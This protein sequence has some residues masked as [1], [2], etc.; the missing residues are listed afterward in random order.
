MSQ[1]I[2]RLNTPQR[3]FSGASQRFSRAAS[4]ISPIHCAATVPEGFQRRKRAVFEVQFWRYRTGLP[5]AYPEV[6][7]GEFRGCRGRAHALLRGVSPPFARD[8]ARARSRAAPEPEGGAGTLT[9]ATVSRV[10]PCGTGKVACMPGTPGWMPGACPG[11]A[12]G[13]VW[14]C[15]GLCQG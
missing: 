8:W 2:S 10:C 3:A 12:R 9:A 5:G 11:G 7:W 15:Q 4:R 14:G 13:N 6:Y 1:H